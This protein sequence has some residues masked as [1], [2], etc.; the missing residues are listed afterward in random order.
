[1]KEGRFEGIEKGGKSEVCGF[2]EA[3]GNGEG[4][5]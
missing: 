3:F 5:E 1:M 2:G 4:C